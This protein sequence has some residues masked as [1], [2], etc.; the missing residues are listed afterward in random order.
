MLE[1]TCMDCGATWTVDPKLDSARPPGRWSGAFSMTG[2]LLA[3][4]RPDL[5][6]GS[7]D[8]AA[9]ET[10][11]SQ[12]ATKREA[13]VTGHLRTCWQCGSTRFKDQRLS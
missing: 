6:S 3:A 4:R 7:S 5:T 2:V 9:A 8:N 1:R 10:A 12:D 11:E 13:D